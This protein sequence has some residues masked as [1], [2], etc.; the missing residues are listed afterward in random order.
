MTEGTAGA[1]A[2]WGSTLRAWVVMTNAAAVGLG[3]GAVGPEVFVGQ[4]LDQDKAGAQEALGF[5]LVGVLGEEPLAV[6]S[7][8]GCGELLVAEE[9]VGGVGVAGAPEEGGAFAVLAAAGKD[10][11]GGFAVEEVV[12]VVDDGGGVGLLA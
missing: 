9:D 10:Y 5:E 11:V 8:P 2:I 1:K 4:G 12:G 3:E 6:A 7:A